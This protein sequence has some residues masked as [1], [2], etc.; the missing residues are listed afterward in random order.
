MSL[1]SR[2]AGSYGHEQVV[3]VLQNL[4]VVGVDGPSGQRQHGPHVVGDDLKVLVQDGV[5]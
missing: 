1:K 2:I 5:A 3:A 4:E